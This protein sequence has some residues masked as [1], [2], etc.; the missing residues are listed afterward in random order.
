MRHLI[1]NGWWRTRFEVWNTKKRINRCPTVRFFFYIKNGLLHNY[2]GKINYHPK[3]T[4]N[5]RNSRKD[6]VAHQI[7]FYVVII[8]QWNN[9]GFKLAYFLYV[10]I[11]IFLYNLFVARSWSIIAIR[12]SLKFYHL[13]LFSH[14]PK[15]SLHLTLLEAFHFA[16]R[17]KKVVFSELNKVEERIK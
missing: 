6:Y 4:K 2:T 11:K 3:T 10:S 9:V 8:R 1:T 7:S 12:P 16:M 17:F 14:V 13:F 5:V 15:Y